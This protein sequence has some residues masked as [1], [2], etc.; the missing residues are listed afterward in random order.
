MGP[1]N[2]HRRK[3][4]NMSELKTNEYIWYV[5]ETKTLIRFQ[6]DNHTDAI[7]Y[8]EENNIDKLDGELWKVCGTENKS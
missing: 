1:R 4:D 5:H 2:P 8:M 7:E 6:A 3:R